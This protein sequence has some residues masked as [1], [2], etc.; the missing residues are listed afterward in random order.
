[1]ARKKKYKYETKA[2]T[3]IHQEDLSK[4]DEEPKKKIYMKFSENKFYSD[5]KNPIFEAGKIYA[6]DGWDWVSRWVKRGG[7]VLENAVSGAISSSKPE[8]Q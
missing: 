8:D 1:M 4:E 7:E 3:E 2:T 5:Q 6:L